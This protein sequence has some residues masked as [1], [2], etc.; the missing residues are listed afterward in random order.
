MKIIMYFSSGAKVIGDLLT[1]PQRKERET[2][3]ELE[4]RIT[5]SLNE[6]Q[7][8]CANKITKCR[9]LRN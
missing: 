6:S 1:P 9:I 2:Q 8:H 4:S 5:I 3:S 7:P